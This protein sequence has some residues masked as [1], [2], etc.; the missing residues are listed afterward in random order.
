MTPAITMTVAINSLIIVTSEGAYYISL[1]IISVYMAVRTM[2]HLRSEG[3]RNITKI[4]DALRIFFDALGTPAIKLEPVSIQKALGRILSEDVVANQFIPSTDQSVMDGYA[5]RSEDVQNASQENPVILE[6]VGESRLGEVCKTT[7]KSGTVVAVATGSMIPSGADT[8]VIIERTKYLPENKIAVHAPATPGQSISRKGEDVAPGKVVL[9]RGRRLRP[10][11]IGILKALGLARVRVVRKPRIAIISTG[12]ELVDSTSRKN[13]GKIVDINRPI[14]SAMVQELGAEPIDLGISK[15]KETEIMRVLRRALGLSDVVLLSAGSSVGKRDLVPECINKIGKPG[16]VVHGIAMRP[17]LPT[18][19]AV[20]NGKPVL[21]LPG[22]PVSAIFA[23]RVFGRALIA[24]L[25][26]TTEVTEPV[27]KA[28]L[29]ERISGPP[30]Y[31][32]FV[33]IAVRRTTEG[34]VA[35]PLKL[36]RSSVLMSMVAANGIVIIP[37]GTT[38]FEAGQTVEVSLIGE[39]LS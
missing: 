36:Q 16:M 26:G 15:D 12:N 20:V 10:Q 21:S 18:G 34:L 14:L 23:F 1:S 38:A 7:V 19:L 17:S 24:K 28:I 30:G 29:K 8:V 13:G 37:E 32:T 3:F 4:D 5:V 27:V 6:V 22:F 35:E 31:R 39:M 25:T 11:D 2:D 9:T 33:R